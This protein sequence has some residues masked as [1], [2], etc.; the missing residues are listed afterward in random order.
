MIWLTK[1]LADAAAAAKWIDALLA[2]KDGWE[3]LDDRGE[4]AWIYVPGASDICANG[5]PWFVLSC[6]T[7][8]RRST[9]PRPPST[10]GTCSG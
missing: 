10:T 5:N 9:H 7:C 6:Q 8:G 3:K 1:N 4:I 2:A